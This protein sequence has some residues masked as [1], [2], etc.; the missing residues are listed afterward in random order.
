MWIFKDRDKKIYELIMKKKVINLVKKLME[1]MNEKE[2]I[3][4]IWKKLRNQNYIN[5]EKIFILSYI[6]EIIYDLYVSKI[7]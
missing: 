5:L 7:R 1:N 3:L 6:L 2:M 4:S